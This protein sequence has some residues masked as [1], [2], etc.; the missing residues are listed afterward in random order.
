GYVLMAMLLPELSHLTTREAG[1]VA[2]LRLAQTAVALERFRSANNNRYPDTLNELA[3]KFMA[4]VALDPFNG[5]PLHYR[6][7]A[8]GY[9][10]YSVGPD[11]KDDNGQRRMGSDDLPF[12]VVRPPKAL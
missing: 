8:T 2:R 1:V 6:K 12:I 3:P 9:V 5:A 7:A 4:S 11:L 10:L